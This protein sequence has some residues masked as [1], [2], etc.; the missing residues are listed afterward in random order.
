MHSKATAR[1]AAYG[2]ADPDDTLN[3]KNY[4]TC[5]TVVEEKRTRHTMCH[6]LLLNVAYGLSILASYFYSCL[7]P[8]IV[9]EVNIP[10]SSFATLVSIIAIASGIGKFVLSVIV[11]MLGAKA[12]FL[13]MLACQALSCGSMAFATSFP[14][15]AVCVL[16]FQ[17]HFCASCGQ[18]LFTWF[19]QHLPPRRYRVKPSGDLALQVALALSHQ[20]L[21][22]V[23]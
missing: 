23:R 5:S 12:S 20:D 6:L 2:N 11:V 15:I 19:N 9:T 3:V 18:P 7:M 21:F 4:Q 22:L 16:R 1:P 17:N 13:L 8:A 14:I 10:S